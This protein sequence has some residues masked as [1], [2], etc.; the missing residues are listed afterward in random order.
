MRIDLAG[1]FPP[2]TTPFDRSGRLNL[3]AFRNNIRDY[4]HY[5]LRGYLVQ[6]SSG[7]A[8]SLD[9]E[10]RIRVFETARKEIPPDKLFI[11]GTGTQSLRETL[12]LTQVATSI[13]ADA[14]LVLPPFYYKPAM[15]PETLEAYYTTLARAARIP[16]LIYS[17]PQFTGYSMS[18]ATMVTLSR[19][20]RIVGL[21]ESSG[22]V[23]YLSEI[24]EVVTPRFQ[25]LTGSALTFFAALTLGARGGILALAN[26]APQESIEIYQDF[27]SGRFSSAAM[28]QRRVMALARSITAGFGVAGLKAGTSLAGFEGGYPRAPLRPLSQKDQAVIR[29]L[30]QEMKLNW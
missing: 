13:G 5:A 14:V 22:N 7:E 16:V 25:C 21:K 11:A 19:Q 12:Q 29:Y 28:K 6:G 24:M 15:T 20:R 1:V 27:K 18:V 8:F 3:Q 23:S 10:E 4:N 26:V 2:L 9:Y 17:I 30:F